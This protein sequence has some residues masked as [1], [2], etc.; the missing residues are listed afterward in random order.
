MGRVGSLAH[1][2]VDAS[3][4][5]PKQELDPLV[6]DEK[7]EFA[8]HVNKFVA[9]CHELASSDEEIDAKDKVSKLILSLP[10]SFSAMAI[11]TSV[12]DTTFDKIAEAVKAELARRANQNNPQSRFASQSARKCIRSRLPRPCEAEVNQDSEAVVLDEADGE[13]ERDH[14]ESW[15]SRSR[16]PVANESPGWPRRQ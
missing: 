5:Q 16:I 10:A 13:V 11:V 3:Q 7:K 9:I 6:F 15:I 2:H 1:D 4:T 12:T 8:V 14:T